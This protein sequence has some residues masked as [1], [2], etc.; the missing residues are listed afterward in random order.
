MLTI[1]ARLNGKVAMKEIKTFCD[2]CG[3]EIEKSSHWED[4]PT[5]VHLTISP[6]AQQYDNTKF[7]EVCRDCW[8][9]IAHAVKNINS[10]HYIK[11]VKE[12]TK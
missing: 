4:S 3:K 1:V 12:P 11:E 5:T 6:P 8:K 2:S 7:E 10:Y 9:K